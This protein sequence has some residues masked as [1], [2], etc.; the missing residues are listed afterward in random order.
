MCKTGEKERMLRK[1]IGGLEL[2][3]VAHMDTHLFLFLL[4]D[5]KA[6]SERVNISRLGEAL[7]RIPLVVFGCLARSGRRVFQ[8]FFHISPPTK[9]TAITRV[10]SAVLFSRTR[11]E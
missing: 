11:Q 5:S 7:T 2:G 9:T 10:I 6:G 1:L 8:T 3:L 4:G